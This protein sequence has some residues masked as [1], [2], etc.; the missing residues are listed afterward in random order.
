MLEQ[1]EVDL[2]AVIPSCPIV[3]TSTL[4]YDLSN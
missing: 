4:L 2:Y 3:G 1:G